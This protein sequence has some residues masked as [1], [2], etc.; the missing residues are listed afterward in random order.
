[1]GMKHLKQ[2]L[3][4]SCNIS[5]LLK[6]RIIKFV[7]VY[8]LLLFYIPSFSQCFLNYDITLSGF[9]CDGKGTICVKGDNSNP[10]CDDY[11]FLFVYPTSTFNPSTLAPYWSVKFSNV[12]I[13]ILSANVDFYS[14]GNLEECFTGTLL[15][16]NTTFTLSLVNKTNPLDVL[17]TTTFK[18]D[19]HKVLT[20]TNTV[21]SLISSTDLLPTTVIGSPMVSSPQKIVIDGTLIVDMDY[22][23][24]TVNHQINNEI[25]LTQN[26][27]IEV[28]SNK[29]FYTHKSIIHKC[30]SVGNWDRILLKPS[31]KYYPSYTKISGAGTAVWLENNAE[32]N[33][34]YTHIF[35][36]VVGLRVHDAVTFPTNAFIYTPFFIGGGT[37][38]RN[39]NTGIVLYKTNN[40]NCRDLMVFENKTGI[41]MYESSLTGLYCYLSENDW[42]INA[43]FNNNL[44]RLDTCDLSDNAIGI[45]SK[46]KELNIYNSQI[47]EAN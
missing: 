42:G 17:Y 38:I 46:V 6:M 25:L 9:Y 37:Q 33:S 4:N 21:S 12:F 45:Y 39:N 20:G 43:M 44:L 29:N 40:I 15:T 3:F 23:F 13:T 34:Y 11:E 41:Y 47:P 27:T 24:S 28:Q 26:S 22:G 35:N 14:D 10:Y 30:P 16:P 7:I 1:M 31:A 8:T 18:L 5:I 32:F 36:N 19:D 2:R